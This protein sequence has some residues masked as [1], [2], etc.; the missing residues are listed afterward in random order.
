V[1]RSLFTIAIVVSSLSAARLSAWN[2][3]EYGETPSGEPLIAELIRIQ[4]DHGV[5]LDSYFR[6]QLYESD[7]LKRSISLSNRAP[8]H[9]GAGYSVIS[10]DGASIAFAGCGV[11]LTEPTAAGCQT[12]APILAVSR[13][14]GSSVRAYSNLENASGMCW[15]SDGAKLAFNAWVDS[16]SGNRSTKLQVLDVVSGKA[17]VV[18]DD[19]S[20][21][22]PQCFSPDGTIVAYTKHVRA[23]RRT[24]F[25]YNTQ[26]KIRREIGLG[27]FATWIP[28]SDW[29]TYLDCGIE[30]HDCTYFA[31]HSDGTGARILFKTTSAVT[32]LSWSADGRFAAY[33]SAS[34][35]SEPRGVGWRLRV[36]R[37]EDNAEDWVANLTDTD[38]IQ[39]QWNS[40]ERDVSRP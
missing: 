31:K 2:G 40:N 36:R 14:D 33:V 38:P 28:A 11:S 19:Q 15:S 1:I 37:Y 27:A 20:F 18:D 21:T 22:M 26:T 7:F 17:E 10:P 32:G 8:S 16:A 30:L 35:E 39:F 3:F 5:T 24:I 13:I 25:S 29:V 4:Q 6:G 23:S 34:R 12:G 9:K